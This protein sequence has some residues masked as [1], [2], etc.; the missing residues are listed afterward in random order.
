MGRSE[1]GS[2]KSTSHGIPRVRPATFEVWHAFDLASML[3]LG[4][5]G[6]QFGDVDLV[7]GVIPATNRFICSSSPSAFA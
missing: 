6:A 2:G 7:A 4:F 3:I 1:H 5:S